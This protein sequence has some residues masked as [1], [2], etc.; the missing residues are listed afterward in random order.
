MSY[1]IFLLVLGA[2]MGF[3]FL[4][5]GPDYRSSY[6][7]MHGRVIYAL[8]ITQDSNVSPVLLPTY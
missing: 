2:H 5:A 8:E 1:G 4:T 6:A 7:E 3:I